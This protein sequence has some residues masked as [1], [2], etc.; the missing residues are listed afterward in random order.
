E[1]RGERGREGLA[2]E[3]RGVG[4]VDPAVDAER[5]VGAVLV[6]AELAREARERHR[7]AE[8]APALDVELHAVVARRADEPHRDADGPALGRAD[9]VGPGDLAGARGGDQARAI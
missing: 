1:R 8:L 4:P 7:V 5:L 9:D 2:V 3:R 6:R